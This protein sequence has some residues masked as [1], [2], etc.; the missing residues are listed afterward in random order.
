MIE[1]GQR[2]HGVPGGQHPG[3]TLEGRL[4]WAVHRDKG[5]YVGQEIIER[6]LS[7]GRLKR[8]L[9]LISSDASDGTLEVGAMVEGGSERDVVSSVVVAASGVLAFAYLPIELSLPG[10]E[11]GLLA[12]AGN[13]R[14]TVLEWPAP[15]P[16][17]GRS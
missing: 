3:L 11:L 14:A 8:Q 17:A 6:A 4:E 9:C 2:A 16:S 1:S 12:A 7:R 15:D 10:T 13:S 5:C